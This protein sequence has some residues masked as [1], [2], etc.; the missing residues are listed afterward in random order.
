MTSCFIHL[1]PSWL[2]ITL[3]W[4]PLDPLRGGE[5]GGEP[6]CQEGINAEDMGMALFLYLLW[7]VLY[8]V[9]TE[10]A[11]KVGLPHFSPFGRGDIVQV[12]CCTY[13]IFVG[14]GVGV[15]SC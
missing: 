3:R 11:D 9:K 8:Y 2:A 13:M 7:Q 1:F 12:V 5:P 4:C 14:G 10:H 6:E 15:R